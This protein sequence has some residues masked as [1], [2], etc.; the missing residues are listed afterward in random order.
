MKTF[1]GNYFE[2]NTLAH[3]ASGQLNTGRAMEEASAAGSAVFRG[4]LSGAGVAV[5]DM[6]V[7]S[8]ANYTLGHDSA[9][10]K[11]MQANWLTPVLTTAGL[12][13]SRGRPTVA[14]G[15][16]TAG[17]ALSKYIYS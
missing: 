12:L 7:G 16:A 1:Q 14:V 4:A 9:T 11:F 3:T 15:L 17:Y 2:Y 10:A 13:L 8:L 6:A 5:G